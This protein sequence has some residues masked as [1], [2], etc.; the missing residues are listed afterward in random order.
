MYRW[1][2]DLGEASIGWAV[3][4]IDVNNREPV[5][6]ADGGVRLFSNSRNPSDNQPRNV[7]RREAYGRRRNA[8]RRLIRMRSVEAWLVQKSAAD[9][10]R[11]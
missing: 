1:A 8:E 6:L 10:V 4:H 2:F 3:F 7:A 11:S 5:A 9:G